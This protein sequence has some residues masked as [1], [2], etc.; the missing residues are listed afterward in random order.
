MDQTTSRVEYLLDQLYQLSK[1][2][3]LLLDVDAQVSPMRYIYVLYR[4]WR[5]EFYD[6]V[7]MI[8]LPIY[9]FDY[10]N[11]K[12]DDLRSFMIDITITW[13][14][15][16]YRMDMLLYE[17]ATQSEIVLRRFEKDGILIL[18]KRIQEKTCELCSIFH[19]HENMEEYLI[20]LKEFFR[21]F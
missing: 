12:F 17:S 6:L 8:Y 4:R 2:K 13:L 11:K 7:D 1:F 5:M 3:Q 14:K 9:E 16:R 21:N 10:Q 18:Y 19:H 20:E 15:L